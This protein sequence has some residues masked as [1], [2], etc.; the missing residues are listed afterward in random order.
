MK[1]KR[2]QKTQ[3][4]IKKRLQEVEWLQKDR[5]DYFLSRK[6]SLS[7]TRPFSCPNGQSKCPGCSYSLPSKPRM[8]N[9]REILENNHYFELKY[10]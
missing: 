4:Y 8:K 7:K 2:I 10:E 9:T 1:T 5:L 3:Q 6:N